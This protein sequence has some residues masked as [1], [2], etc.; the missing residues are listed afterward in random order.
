MSMSLLLSAAALGALLVSAQAPNYNDI[1]SA[2]SSSCSD[3]IEVAYLCETEYSQSTDIF[4]CFCQ[5]LPTD[6]SD[7]ST[8]VTSNNAA[9]LGSLMS[10][11]SATCTTFE[12]QCMFE[13]SFATCD[14]TDIACQCGDTYLENIFNCASCN[15]ANGNTAATQLTD[16]QSLNASCYAQNYT[17]PLQDFATVAIASPTGQADY[18][19]PTLTA[20]G[21]GDAAT[22]DASALAAGETAYGSDSGA[23]ASASAT[24]AATAAAAG[25]TSVSSIASASKA[26][27]VSKAASASKAA[28]TAKT[29][30]SASGA[31]TAASASASTA[32]GF[33]G[34]VAPTLGGVLALAGAVAALF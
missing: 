9:S 16:F 33:Q 29:S 8:C 4:G 2:C 17:G 11:A 26:T 10:A 25:I 13:C 34:F 7:C 20:T 22:G 19:A 24:D 30:A 5:S 23:S 3:T 14:S 27:S 1:P 12:Q 28:T 18:S 15:T 31:A 21:G 6:L 32:A